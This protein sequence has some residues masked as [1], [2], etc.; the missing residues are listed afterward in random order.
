MSIKNS[1][2]LGAGTLGS[3]VALQSSISGF[4]VR[5]YDVQ[6]KSLDF[7]LNT[8]QKILHQLHKSGQISK[9]QDLDILS[10]IKFTLD[11]LE[12][13]ED[14]D[15]IN[16]SVTEDVDIKK[17]VWKQFGEIAPEKTIFT[18]NT[19][20]M[21]ASMFAEDSG[22]PER[23]CAFHFHDV[24]YSRVVDI[25]P[26]PTTD[27]AL[28]PI[29]EDLGR[30]LN[31]VPV[32]LK[33]ENPGYIF[34]TMLMALIGAAGKLLTGEVA[35][36]EDIDKSWMVNFHMPM[37]PFGILDSIGLDTAWHVT[38]KMPDRASVA[39]AALLKTYIDQGKLGEKSGEGFYQYPNPRYKAQD[40]VK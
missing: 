36:I 26:H 19:S 15:F 17:K 10:R 18:T 22:R 38:H 25:M 12:A 13:V 4:H 24:F 16:E 9:G 31:Q 6:Q 34:N 7:S 27:P 35:S 3:R 23:F 39:F 11:P 5:V 37:G 28:I 30:K 2:I 8:M 29:L 33:K 1:C 14:A 21:L 40:F 20:Y 32:I